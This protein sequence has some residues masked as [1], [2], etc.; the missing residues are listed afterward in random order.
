VE[1][2]ISN[3]NGVV[4][5]EVIDHGPGIPEAEQGRIFGRLYR[6]PAIEQ[7]VPGSGLG[8]SIAQNIARAHRGDLTVRS[9]PGNTAFRLTLPV[10]TKMEA[11]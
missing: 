9:R 10:E 6:S 3:G 4:T 5:V 7:Q 8:L 11:R 1:I 2:Q